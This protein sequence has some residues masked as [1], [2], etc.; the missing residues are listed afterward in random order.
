MVSFLRSVRA[1]AAMTC[2]LVACGGRTS[3]VEDTLSADAAASVDPPASVDAAAPADPP[4]SVDAA[5]AVDAGRCVSIDPSSYDASCNVDS[6]CV[7][8][9]SGTLCIN[10]CV[11][12]R[13]QYAQL[14]HGIATLAINAA[15]RAKYDADTDVLKGACPVVEDTM[16]AGFPATC[17]K[18][19]C[20]AGQGG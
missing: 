6:D 15:A 16:C 4:A 2:L 17:E 20:V 5:V 11:L 7:T 12:C 10:D 3:V 18:H 9:G 14:H 19:Q 8:V 1:A 13:G